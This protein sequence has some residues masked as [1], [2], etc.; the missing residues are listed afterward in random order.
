MRL[1]AVDPGPVNGVV[2]INRRA[3]D[4]PP[5]L[6]W[7]QD[8]MSLAKLQENIANHKPDLVVCEW[9]S[10]MGLIVGADVFDT[11][12]TVGRIEQWCVDWSVRFERIKRVDVKLDVLGQTRGTD[13]NVR[14]A[15]LE[16]YPQTGGGKTPAVGTKAQPGPLYGLKGH[17]T[18]AL[19]AGVA[20]LRREGA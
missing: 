10:S 7:S 11:C 2:L 20:W 1:L 9:V 4:W 19:A 15:M 3:G 16:M 17:A 18:Q 13:S 5:R 14:G 6:V 12:R 8:D